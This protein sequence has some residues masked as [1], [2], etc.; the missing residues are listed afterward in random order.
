M[1]Y[2]WTFPVTQNVVNDDIKIV[3][4]YNLV[5]KLCIWMEILNPAIL[6][7]LRDRAMSEGEEEEVEVHGCG[8]PLSPTL[9]RHHS[10][11]PSLNTDKG[12]Q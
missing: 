12:N 8:L 3:C 6:G 7:F 11:P 5:C 9:Y 4:K 10:Q 2:W 1:R